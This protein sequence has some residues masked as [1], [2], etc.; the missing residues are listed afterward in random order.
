MPN[1]SYLKGFYPIISANSLRPPGRGRGAADRHVRAACGA[2]RGQW[3]HVSRGVAV[4]N[5]DDREAYA[6]APS[7]CSATVQLGQDRLGA[8]L[9]S[10]TVHVSEPHRMPQRSACQQKIDQRNAVPTRSGLYPLSAVPIS[11]VHR[12]NAR[13]LKYVPRPTRFPICQIL[14]SPAV[15]SSQSQIIPEMIQ[16]ERYFPPSSLPTHA[17]ER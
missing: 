2:L 7:A 1:A 9:A 15:C 12:R 3:P 16:T 14:A 4:H 5:L 13:S 8:V 17:D 6:R 10:G 11:S